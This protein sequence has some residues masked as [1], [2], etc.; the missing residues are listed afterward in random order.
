MKLDIM[1]YVSIFLAIVILLGGWYFD[2]QLET[3]DDTIYTLRTDLLKSETAK[4]LC[5]A[6][7]S[8]LKSTIKHQNE[9]IEKN[10]INKKEAD[11]R[12][13]NRKKGKDFV[14]EWKI[15]SGFY[16]TNSTKGDNC[17]TNN[18]ILGA[19]SKYGF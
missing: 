11:I 5:E 4:A 18:D 10:K 8:T 9:E 13:N 19:I 12:W 14:E 16:D 7:R 3:K 2:S 17:E 6:N 15:K 1:K